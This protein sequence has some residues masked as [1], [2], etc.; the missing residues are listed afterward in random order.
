MKMQPSVTIMCFL[1]NA[2]SWR[3]EHIFESSLL[4]AFPVPIFEAQLQATV[5]NYGQGIFEG[6]KAQEVKGI[7]TVY[8]YTQNVYAHDVYNDMSYAMQCD[9][10][11]GA[12]M[13]WQLYYWPEWF[14]M[15]SFAFEAAA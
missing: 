6:L 11:L 4:S 7:Y 12:I 1:Q 5:L 2:T 13:I 9:V 14:K 8:I 10:F 15:L 3:R